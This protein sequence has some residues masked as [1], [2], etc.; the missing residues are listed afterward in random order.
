MEVF[1]KYGISFKIIPETG[2]VEGTEGK[3]MGRELIIAEDG[4]ECMGVYDMILSTFVY[5]RCFPY[6]FKKLKSRS[7]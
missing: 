6:F 5:V 2:E 7:L 4:E 1:M 3:K